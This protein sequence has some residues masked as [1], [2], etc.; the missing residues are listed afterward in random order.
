MPNGRLGILL[1]QR[2]AIGQIICKSVPTANINAEGKSLPPT[3]WSRRG[4][5]S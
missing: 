1:G 4:G 2:G 5:V 3:V